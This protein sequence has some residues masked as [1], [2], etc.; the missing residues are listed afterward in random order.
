MSVKEAIREAYGLELARLG[1]E[2]PELLVLDADVSKSTRTLYF[3]KAFPDRFF[4]FGIAEQNMMAA[5][6]GMST[7]GF[8]PIVNTF[9]FLA[10]YRAADQFRTSIVYPKLNV[11]VAATYGGLS[12]S[13]DGPTHQTVADIAWVRAL[14]GLSVIVPSDAEEMR[15]A[16]PAIIAHRGPVWFRL[17]RAE[18]EVY[19]SADY[20]FRFGKSEIVRDGADV[21]II[22]C[23]V[24][25]PRI[26]QAA[27]IL[28]G[29]GIDPLVMNVPTLKPFDA[30]AV[31]A[32][33]RKTGLI[34]TVEEHNVI[35]GLGSAVCEAVAAENTAS[36]IRLGI[37]DT[38]A[39]SGPYDKLLD[40]Y[41][42]SVDGIVSAVERLANNRHKSW[43][44]ES[45]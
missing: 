3:A 11:K 4:N 33:A 8:V 44:K 37:P 15:K 35:G 34:V 9:S 21:S 20:Q 19:H 18:T 12:D 30:E 27:A 10:T 24:V 14:P 36:V 22:G 6:A 41:G 29:K 31:C 7:I 5:A 38:F 43:G 42:L 2:M 16:L 39:E 17:C 26:L 40:R 28:S 25:M 1:R 32:A 13:Y 45:G 23:G